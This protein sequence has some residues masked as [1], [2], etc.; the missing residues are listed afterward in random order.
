[1][2]SLQQVLLKGELSCVHT[3]VADTF[4]LVVCFPPTV[5][6]CSDVFE[7]GSRM[8]NLSRFD[9]FQSSNMKEKRDKQI[10]T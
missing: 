6:S 9:N 7:E 3:S 5:F 4:D 10:E 8:L 2:C 1:M